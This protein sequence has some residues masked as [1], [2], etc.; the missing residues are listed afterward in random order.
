MAWQMKIENFLYRIFKFKFYGI[1][2]DIDFVLIFVKTVEKTKIITEVQAHEHACCIQHTAHCFQACEMLRS[3]CA[4]L[5]TTGAGLILRCRHWR[6]STRTWWPDHAKFRCFGCWDQSQRCDG[7]EKAVLNENKSQSVWLSLLWWEVGKNE[8]GSQLPSECS[9]TVIKRGETFWSTSFP[10]CLGVVLLTDL[11]KE[12]RDA[13][14][15]HHKSARSS[16]EH[17]PALS[18]ASLP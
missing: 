18:R 4:K 3:S 16:P 11:K 14:P 15:R 9:I 7:A 13:L 1:C 6:P 2:I 8:S 5:E 10:D 17:S 12:K